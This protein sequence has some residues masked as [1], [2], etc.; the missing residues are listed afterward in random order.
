MPTAYTLYDV[1]KSYGGQEILSGVDL[2]IDTSARLAVI[3]R[4]GAGKST[5]CRL[6]LGQEQADGGEVEKS[7]GVQVAHLE[8]HDPFREGETVQ[9]F[10]E[11]TSLAPGWRCGEV[12]GK[13]GIGAD[14]LTAPILALSGGWQTRARLCGMLLHDPDLLILDEPTNYLDLRTQLL[15][16]NFLASFKGGWLVVSHDRSF[17]ERTCKQTL[18]VARGQARFYPGTPSQWLQH[19]QDRKTE[20]EARNANLIIRRKELEEFV[21]RNKAKASKATQAASKMKQIERLDDEMVEVDAD[22]NDM[23]VIRLPKV[24]VRPGDCVRL[25]GMAIGYPERMVAKNIDLDI[26][27]GTKLA[28][29]GDNGQGKSTFLKTLAGELPA[30]AGSAKWGYGVRPGHYHQHVHRSLPDNKTAR[31]WLLTVARTAPG[32]MITEQDV[33][34]LAGAFLLRGAAVDKK[35]AVLSGGERARLVLAGLLLNRHDCLLLDE[36]T[37]HLDVETVEALAD[38]LRNY[39]GTVLFIS[40]DRAFVSRLATAVV[41]VR[42]GAVANY[43]GSYDDYVWRVERE[44]R[45]DVSPAPVAEKKEPGT[46]RVANP[47]DPQAKRKRL[48]AV[49]REVKR[50]DAR[51]KELEAKL[52]NGWDDTLGKELTQVQATLAEREEEWL[53]LSE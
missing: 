2:T 53:S 8:Q 35:I 26:P 33:L 21:A 25:S 51:R 49:E 50:L 45:P 5:L 13:F 24:E 36:P 34:D 12:A 17:L 29:V 23:P 32:P 42:D 22:D 4:N 39:N 47:G 10:L 20:A 7:E 14:K 43:P 52:G 15:L 30:L 3:G 9:D 6:L 16:E 27:R 28:V 11:R 18:E 48:Q 41:E 1:H 38:G 37:N 46:A 19:K 44:V 31:E 40:H